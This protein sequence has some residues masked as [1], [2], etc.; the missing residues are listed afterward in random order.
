M[1]KTT[2]EESLE[3][4]ADSL[5]ELNS[6]MQWFCFMFC[7]AFKKPLKTIDSCGFEYADEKE[8]QE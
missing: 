1:E 4:I 7:D 3:S 8:L 6:T 5:Y 2:I